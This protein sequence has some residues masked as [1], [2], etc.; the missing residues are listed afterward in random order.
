MAESSFF[1]KGVSV[2]RVACI[3]SVENFVSVRRPLPGWS[4]V[5]FGL[6]VIAACLEKAG[7]EVQCWVLCPDTSLEAVAGEVLQDFRAEMIAASAVSTQFPLISS[8]CRQIKALSPGTAILLGG[9]HSSL[10][11]DDAIASGCMDAICIGE[12]EDGC[13]AYANAVTERRQPRGIPGLWIKVPGETGIDRTPA[14][15]FRADLDELPFINLGHW[16]R[17]VHKADLAFRIVIGRGC[18]YGCTYCSNHALKHLNPGR[19][20]R[21]RSPANILQEIHFLISKHP[22]IDVLHLEIE[23]IGASLNFAVELCDRLA[24]FNAAREHPILF[25][26]NLAVTTGLVRDN[27]RLHALLAA[28]DRANLRYLNV[29]LESGSERIRKEILRRPPYTNSDL[30]TFCQAARQYNV[31]VALFVLMGL[32]TETVADVLETAA[33]ARACEPY[34]LSESIFYP[35]PGTKL[36]D[37][38]AEMDLFDPSCVA[39][40][41]ERSRA[42]LRLKDFP[43]SRVLFEYVFITWRVFH[44]RWDL[45][46]LTRR[47]AYKAFSV[48]PGLLAA[49]VRIRT[50]LRQPAR[51]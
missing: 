43:P 26:A 29:G 3:F 34:G 18:P 14:P 6:S 21:F 39:T 13:V 22:E 36:Y 2:A 42:Y 50:A 8:F 5:P 4:K 27:A 15:P 10:N 46:R 41:A 37:L 51:A 19:Y 40:V 45:L 32:P 35:Y 12:G 24:E 33:V 9:V 17:W 23:T 16:E 38:S 1:W 48:I 11:P 30:I 28:F 7:H 20:L 47:M 31:N 49:A 25:R 44:G